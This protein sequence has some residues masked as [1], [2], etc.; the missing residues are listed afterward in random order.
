[1]YHIPLRSTVGANYEVDY[2]NLLNK[3]AQGEQQTIAVPVNDELPVAPL[4]FV[5]YRIKIGD[6][7]VSLAIRFNISQNKIRRYNNNVCFGHRL[8]HMIGKLLLI[9]ITFD[10]NLTPEV[11]EQLRAI[12]AA[13]KAEEVKEDGEYEEPNEDGKYQLR[14]AFLFH[15]TGVDV[16]RANYYLGICECFY[17]CVS[18]L[19][20]ILQNTPKEKQI[21]MLEKH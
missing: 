11:Q 4:G 10:A 16:C 17:S 12:Y 13:D 9:P 5:F 3:L 21:G 1:M 15:C 7:L 14:K 18:C 19:G 8:T 6:T 2:N 20:Q